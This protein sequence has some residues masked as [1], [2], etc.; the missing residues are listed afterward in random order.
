MRNEKGGAKMKN[1]KVFTFSFFIS[2]L[3]FL[4]S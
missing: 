3:L 4:I 1:E 2:N